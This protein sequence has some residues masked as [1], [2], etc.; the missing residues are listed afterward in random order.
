MGDLSVTHCPT[1]RMWADIFTKPKQGKDFRVFRGEV[2][3]CLEVYDD[4]AEAKSDM[5]A[6]RIKK[7]RVGTKRNLVKTKTLTSRVHRMSVLSVAKNGDYRRI[8]EKKNRLQT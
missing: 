2:M 3:N 4:A 1:R 8:A 5:I 7:V 6:S